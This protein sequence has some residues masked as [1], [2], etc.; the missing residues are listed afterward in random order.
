M[1]TNLPLSLSPALSPIFPYLEAGPWKVGP[2]TIHIFGI[3][4]ALG[5]LTASYFIQHRAFKLGLNTVYS[6]EM[7]MWGI[8]G[9]FIGAHLFEILLYQPEKIT[10]DPL[11]LLKIWEGI[12]SFGG[13]L[14][15]VIA[16]FIYTKY[17]KLNFIRWFDL[18]IWGGIHGWI[19]GRIGCSFAHDH[20]GYFT[21]SWFSVKW[22]VNHIDQYYNINNYPGRH[23]LGL[24]ELLY[25]FIILGVFYLLNRKGDKFKGFNIALLFVL[26]APA[27]FVMDFLRTT[28]KTYFL[29][30]PAQYASIIMFGVGITIFIFKSPLLNKNKEK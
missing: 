5:V 30:T 26:Y 13:L 27:R 16:V 20:P 7:T 4:V 2:F 3:M 28:D 29:L 21:D 10:Q 25:T 15:L 23:D 18:I 14:G 22:P 8:I 1:I 17:R 24:Y 19:P 9:V 12:A 11:I 6:S